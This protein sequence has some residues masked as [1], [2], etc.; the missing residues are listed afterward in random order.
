MAEE[1]LKVI[2]QCGLLGKYKVWYLQFMLI[3][4]LLW[5]LLIYDISTSTV[6]AMEAKINKYTRKWLGAHRVSLTLR[7]TV[8]RQS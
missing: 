6:E 4:K 2:D 5:P 8:V 7:S 3:P 1:S